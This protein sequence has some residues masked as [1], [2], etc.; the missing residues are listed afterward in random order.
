MLFA[1][2]SSLYTSMGFSENCLKAVSALFSVERVNLPPS[3][4]TSPM[5]IV[6]VSGSVNLRQL[7]SGFRDPK[8]NLVSKWSDWGIKCILF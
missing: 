7:M 3:K 5:R 8:A 6:S 1:A 4:P 2:R